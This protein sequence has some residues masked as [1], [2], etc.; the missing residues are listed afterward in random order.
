MKKNL[1]LIGMPGSG[2]TTLGRQLSERLNRPFIDLDEEI[3][4]YSNQSIPALFKKGE[5]HFRAIET[6]VTEKISQQ[7]SLVIATGGGIVLREENMRA[8]RKNGRIIFLNRSLENI[9][10]D[11]EMSSRP[12]L[13]DGLYKLEILYNERIS[14][15][16]RYADLIIDNNQEADLTI[17]EILKQLSI[18]TQEKGQ[19]R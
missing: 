5:S 14:S 4:K 7:S 1:V 13:K 17:K 18:L 10:T 2:K 19:E 9:A 3:E 12:L 15:Y 11:V 16:Q 6:K 8:L